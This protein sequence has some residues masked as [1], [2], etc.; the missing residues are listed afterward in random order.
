MKEM[1]HVC[2]C[3]NWILY[4]KRYLPY[5]LTRQKTSCHHLVD[6]MRF[7]EETQW[8]NLTNGYHYCV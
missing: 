8:T 7:N 2:L 1:F 6:V 5:Y 3:K 4:A